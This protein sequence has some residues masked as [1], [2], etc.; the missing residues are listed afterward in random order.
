MTPNKSPLV[1]EY[2]KA[3]D[4]MATCASRAYPRR[5]GHTSTFTAGANWGSLNS[6][7]VKMLEE[8]VRLASNEPMVRLDARAVLDKTLA[9]LDELRRECGENKS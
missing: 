8:A 4:E 2:C 7:V 1:R 6:P 5:M 9:S 3:R